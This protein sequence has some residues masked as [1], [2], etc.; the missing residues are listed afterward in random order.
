MSRRSHLA[1]VLLLLLTVTFPLSATAAK[2]GATPTAQT[3]TCDTSVQMEDQARLVPDGVTVIYACVSYNDVTGEYTVGAHYTIAP[4]TKIKSQGSEDI[5]QFGSSYV[6]VLSGAL[7]VTLVARC[8]KFPLPI[9]QPLTCEQEV[10]IALYSTA[11][12]DGSIKWEPLNPGQMQT[13]DAGGSI[14]LV[15]VTVHYH[16]AANPNGGA[17]ISSIGTYEGSAGGGCGLACWQP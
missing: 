14:W 16:A 13:I 4:D 8:A 15:N 10:G 9:T 2:Q 3:V 6:T 17:E 7:D 5:F 12:P 11:G 1:L